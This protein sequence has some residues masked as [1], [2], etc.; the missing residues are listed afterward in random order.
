[1]KNDYHIDLEKFSLAEFKKDLSESELI[2][3]R[4]ILKKDIN[5]RFNVLEDYDIC[6]LQDLAL[7]LKTPKKVRE[8]AKNTGLDEKYLLIL[9]R[10]VNSYIPKAVNLDKFPGVNPETIKKLEVMKIK[11]TLQLF[12]RIKTPELRKDLA[13]ELGVTPEEILELAKLTD[14]VRVKWIGPV[15]ARIF[16]DSGTDTAEKISKSDTE[17]LYDKLVKINQENSYTKAKFLESDVA[18][19][20][21]VAAMVP[22]VIEF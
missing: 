2:P 17:P 18:L 20:I 9:K 22:Q 12:K 21:K 14:L 3:S 5:K 7:A 19:C 10:E 15:F 16:L 4:Q 11:N 6:N 13:D 8:F 1:M